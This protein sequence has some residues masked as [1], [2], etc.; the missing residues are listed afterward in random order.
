LDIFTDHFIYRILPQLF[1]SHLFSYVSISSLL[2]SL[3]RFLWFHCQD[4]TSAS[5]INFCTCQNH[6]A[7]AFL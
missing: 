5:S 3:Y 1:N 6:Q 7:I 2:A 4:T